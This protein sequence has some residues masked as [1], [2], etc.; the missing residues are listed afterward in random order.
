MTNKMKLIS[1]LAAFAM[2]GCSLEVDNPNS[3]LEADL[4][5]PRLPAQ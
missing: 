3:L 4:K 1:L 2:V 5:L